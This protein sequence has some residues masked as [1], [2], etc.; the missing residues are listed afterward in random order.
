MNTTYLAIASML[1]TASLFACG[2]APDDEEEQEG[3]ALSSLDA[4]KPTAKVGT[5]EWKKQL[6]ACIAGRTDGAKSSGGAGQ[7]GSGTAGKDGTAS[8]SSSGC[9]VSISCTGNNACVC[10]TPGREGITCGGSTCGTVCKV[11]K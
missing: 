2:G 6:D 9:R 5:P 7:P 8:T 10:T 3:T 11:C 4:C 1:V